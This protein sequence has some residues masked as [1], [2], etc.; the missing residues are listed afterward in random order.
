MLESCKSFDFN[1]VESRC[2]FGGAV[3]ANGTNNHDPDAHYYEKN[4]SKV[5][6]V[7][8][9]LAPIPGA[10][11]LHNLFSTSG[12]SLNYCANTC[13]MLESCKSFDFN[14]VNSGCYL[15]SAVMA[16]GTN[17]HDPDAHYMYYEKNNSSV[18]PH[19]QGVSC[20]G[21]LFVLDAI[22]C[23]YVYGL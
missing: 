16:N 20:F 3:M 1:Y 10:L 5:V 9:F 13:L 21:N 14:H 15:G 12:L 6:H 8:G 18:S 22:K 17:N 11:T 19:L 4:N 7:S 23:T 2:Y